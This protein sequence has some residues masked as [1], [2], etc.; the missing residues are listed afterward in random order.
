MEAIFEKIINYRE[1]A[2]H[3]FRHP[4]KHSK[5]RAENIPADQM[6]EECLFFGSRAEHCSSGKTALFSA[7]FRTHFLCNRQYSMARK[8]GI[9]MT[10][11]LGISVTTRTLQHDETVH[12]QT[13][14]SV[15][16][17]RVSRLKGY[18]VKQIMRYGHKKDTTA[19]RQFVDAGFR[20]DGAPA[21][22]VSLAAHL[23]IS[24]GIRHFTLP[25]TVGFVNN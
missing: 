24:R 17:E 5:R 14:D 2:T 19:A 8:T 12:E 22:D 1:A 4:I 16:T 15:S 23:L 20:P 11:N 13:H 25:E 18:R 3:D 10:L 9:P 6:V 21:L 7:F